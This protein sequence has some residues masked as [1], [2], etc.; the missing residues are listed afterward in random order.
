MIGMFVGQP[1]CTDVGR[2]ETGKSVSLAYGAQAFADGI[3]LLESKIAGGGSSYTAITGT[4]GILSD[5][6]LPPGKIAALSAG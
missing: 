6:C 3:E 5:L 2:V 4:T 1:V